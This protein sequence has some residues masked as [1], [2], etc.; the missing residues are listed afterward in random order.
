MTTLSKIKRS[1]KLVQE[2][3]E[4]PVSKSLDKENIS[5][6]IVKRANQIAQKLKE[7]SGRER[8]NRR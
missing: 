6:D 8:R 4:E 7:V 5:K 2:F 3:L 1:S